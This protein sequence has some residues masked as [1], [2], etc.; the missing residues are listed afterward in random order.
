MDET[1]IK[2]AESYLLDAKQRVCWNCG[3][4]PLLS[5]SACCKQ[6]SI[7]APLF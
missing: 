6:G 7:L 1:V 4:S 5:T 3:K 2:W